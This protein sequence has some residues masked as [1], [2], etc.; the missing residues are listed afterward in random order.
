MTTTCHKFYDSW[1]LDSQTFQAPID[2]SLNANWS[3]IT[4]VITIWLDSNVIIMFLN[5]PQFCNLFAM[6]SWLLLL[7]P[8]NESY[9]L[10]HKQI[11]FKVSWKMICK[12]LDIASASIRQVLNRTLKIRSGLR[13]T[14]VKKTTNEPMVSREKWIY[15]SFLVTILLKVMS[16]WKW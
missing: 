12:K 7:V 14:V 2:N 10:L 6:R 13:W 9:F 3:S 11:H 8:K 5:W 4:G 15:Q 1:F 16:P